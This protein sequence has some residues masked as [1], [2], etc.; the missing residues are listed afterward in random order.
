MEIE[1][2]MWGISDEFRKRFSENF[3]ANSC[4]SIKNEGLELS[5]AVE[6]VATSCKSS[7]DNRGSSPSSV[8]VAYS[9]TQNQAF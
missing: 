6:I 8:L 9:G 5:G 7:K 2:T 4:V 3:F 1:S